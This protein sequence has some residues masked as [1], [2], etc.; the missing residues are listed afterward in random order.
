MA[1]QRAPNVNEEDAV[2]PQ[3]AEVSPTRLHAALQA[4]T[5]DLTAHDREVEAN[6]AGYRA[7]DLWRLQLQP[8]REEVLDLVGIHG[9]RPGTPCVAGYQ[10]SAAQ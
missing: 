4:R 1:L 5:R 7:D 3:R 10:P 6:V 8:I 9:T 2:G